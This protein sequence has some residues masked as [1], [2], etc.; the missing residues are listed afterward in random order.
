MISETKK[1]HNTN[2]I[3]NNEHLCRSRSQTR[4]RRVK[5]SYHS[6]APTRARLPAQVYA[7][8]AVL[9]Q[10]KPNAPLP[11]QSFQARPQG[12][13]PSPR[14]S[15]NNGPVG[16]PRP[17]QPGQPLRRL[18]SRSTLGPPPVAGQPAQLR[19]YGPPRPP[20]GAAF[21]PR[22]PQPGQLPPQNQ[23]FAFPPG[24]RGPPP[25]AAAAGQR[26]PFVGNQ[27][28]YQAQQQQQQQQRI[29]NDPRFQRPPDVAPQNG[30]RR[31]SQESV[32]PRQLSRN[33]SLLTLQRQQLLSNEELKQPTRPRI[34]IEKMADINEITV[35]KPEGYLQRK[36]SDIRE[37][38]ENDDDDDV[39][40]DSEKSSRHNGTADGLMNGSKSPS[41]PRR[42]DDTSR[43]DTATIKDKEGGMGDKHGV[44][45]RPTSAMEV[46]RVS[47]PVISQS[48]PSSAM[49]DDK[50][51]GKLTTKD[52]PLDKVSRP[53][54]AVSISEPAE[55]IK[56]S[57]A[58]PYH[59]NAPKNIEHNL[60]PSDT[61]RSATPSRLDAEQELKTPA[62]GP[63]AER[64]TLKTPSKTPDRSRS[65][66]PAGVEASS[67]E[68]ESAKEGT[69][70]VKQSSRP[71][72]SLGSPNSM[73]DGKLP[74]SP[75]SLEE[76]VKGFDNGQ[77]R[78][79]SSN[80]PRSPNSPNLPAAAAKPAEGE[81]KRAS[82]VEDAR[83]D[84]EDVA[85]KAATSKSTAKTPRAQ[86][87][88]TLDD[89]KREKK[90]SEKKGLC[91]FAREPKFVC[92][93]NNSRFC[94]SIFFK[95][96]KTLPAY[97]QLSVRKN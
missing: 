38:G 4:P 1:E 26:P 86:T 33:D 81:K 77:Q 80:S 61:S 35:D 78:S 62:S 24:V 3:Y 46:A 92:S 23:R 6:R 47:T 15:I 76:D 73:K 65:S 64:E 34:V 45:S 67:D 50:E 31:P 22:P 83:K 39:V 7:T 51:E 54:S 44:A 95:N 74:K 75:R 66:T 89:G 94:L 96:S 21:P 71:A 43:P 41:T 69:L 37:N 12:P 27:Q 79:L 97:F 91:A 90:S 18:D 53:P 52:S 48:R 10:V 16:A 5:L 88:S 32:L 82:F 8:R 70:Q 84:A 11:Q 40:M 42:L 93:A 14:N 49:N 29:S 58:S 30:P 57:S 55:V 59:K 68:A 9:P 28:A 60:K 56:I 19:P 85:D 72:S 36:K 2:I 25:Q 20:G 63:D 13:P 87:P 17:G